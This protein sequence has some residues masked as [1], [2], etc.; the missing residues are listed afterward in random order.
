M[1]HANYESHKD[2]I[3]MLKNIAFDELKIIED[4]PIFKLEL[5]LK[6]DISEPKI[7]L[8]TNIDLIEEYPDKRPLIEI[9]DSSNYLPSKNI[10]NMITKIYEFIEENIGMPVI[11]QIYEM[12]KDFV[13]TEES[14]LNA[15]VEQKQKKLEEQKQ[16]EKH[17]SEMQLLETKTFTSVNKESYEKWFK[18]FVDELNKVRKNKKKDEMAARMSGREFF[19]N[20]KNPKD[21]EAEEKLEE[22]IEGSAEKP[23]DALFYD[24][25]VFDEDIDNIDFDKIG[26]EDD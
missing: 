12:L 19:M 6:A 24:Q 21:L 8:K 26:V 5:T 15:E 2:E 7:L 17:D 10:K 25:Q 13:N 20:L 23:E 22:E 11:Y 3:E 4:S 1:N 14:T 9:T 18:G 16:K